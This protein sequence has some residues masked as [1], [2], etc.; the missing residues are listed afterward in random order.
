MN[1]IK[2]VL[3]PVIIRK[4]TYYE[5][6]DESSTF[7]LVLSYILSN[8]RKRSVFGRESETIRNAYLIYYPI[9]IQE[10]THTRAYV[11]DFY[12]NEELKLT[13]KEPL[14][15]LV[16]N[17]IGKLKDLKKEQFIHHLNKIINIL[18]DMIVKEKYFITSKV[19]IKNIVTDEAFLKDI[20]FTL[21]YS[22]NKWFDGYMIKT[23]KEYIESIVTANSI[24]IEKLLRSNYKIMNTINQLIPLLDHYCNVWK[25]DLETRIYELISEK[26]RELEIT[27]KKTDLRIHELQ[28][29]LAKE[30]EDIEKSY[31]PLVEDLSKQMNDLT[32]RISKTKVDIQAGKQKILANQLKKQIKIMEKERESL[33]RRLEVLMRRIE[34]EK[35]KISYEYRKLVELELK[36]VDVLEKEI[37][38]LILNKNELIETAVALIQRIKNY[39]VQINDI[40]SRN[41]LILFRYSINTPLKG[42]GIYLI[43]YIIVDYKSRKGIREYVVPP[44]CIDIY[45]FSRP[46]F[47]DY[48]SIYLYLRRS[49]NRI[50]NKYKLYKSNKYD[51]LNKVSLDEIIDRAKYLLDHRIID[52]NMYNDIIEFIKSIR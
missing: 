37:D 3:P 19:V 29:R 43:P 10:I 44:L 27:R 14:I 20:N 5:T 21:G 42:S 8:R 41:Q 6:I 26:K 32:V 40:V 31:K 2:G 52:E 34:E 35:R 7:V 39:L 15:D 33:S 12:A 22:F 45:G 30:I 23:S 18:H 36:K 48:N 46:K 24:Q 50:M 9:Y 38:D 13:H 1:S 11:I 17:L 51:L 25:K 47:F 16:T 28:E 4:S 49:I